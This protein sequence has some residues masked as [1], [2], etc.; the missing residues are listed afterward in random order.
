[1]AVQST[2]LPLGSNLPEFHL[3]DVRTD[4]KSSSAGLTGDANVVIF[5]CNHC[6]YVKHVAAGLA[7]FG[8]DFA[9]DDRVRV[10][11][12]ASNDA[13]HYPDDAPDE[14]ARVADEVGYPFPVLYD[15]SQEVAKA[16]TAACTPDLFVFDS[17]QKLTYRGRFDA[18]RPGNGEPVTGADLRAAVA[19]TI[20]GEPI[21]DQAPSM[22]C[23]IKW[24]RGQEPAWAR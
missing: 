23:G 15:E 22:G 18:A 24:K 4:E 16:F 10:V 7:A 1:M 11:A 9:D 6:P 21:P 12:I 14:L 2:M 5:H 8:R 13:A 3:P 17:G 20:A 19:A